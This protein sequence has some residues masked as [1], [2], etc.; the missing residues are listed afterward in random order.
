MGYAK[1]RATRT[2]R[3][4]AKLRQSRPPETWPS[5][6]A[7]AKCGACFAPLLGNSI[8]YSLRRVSRIHPHFSRSAIHV[9]LFQRFLLAFRKREF[10]HAPFHQV[11][12]GD[13]HKGARRVAHDTERRH[14]DDDR[15]IADHQVG[16]VDDVTEAV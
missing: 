3:T 1:Q 7:A 10:A 4:R 12:A 11:I 6:R 14:A 5:L 15:W 13:T 9:G 16:S 2:E 8:D